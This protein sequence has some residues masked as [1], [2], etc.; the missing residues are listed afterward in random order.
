[1]K[2]VIITYPFYMFYIHTHTLTSTNLN[3]TQHPIDDISHNN[4]LF[5]VFV[6]RIFKGPCN[7]PSPLKLKTWCYLGLNKLHPLKFGPSKQKEEIDLTRMKLVLKVIRKWILLAAYK[8]PCWKNWIL[9]ATENKSIFVSFDL[10]DLSFTN[11]FY[12]CC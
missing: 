8:I 12:S 11:N 9:S 7:A 2:K 10:S 1:M 5:M 4:E 6:K 3:A